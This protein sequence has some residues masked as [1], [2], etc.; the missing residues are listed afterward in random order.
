MSKNLLYEVSDVNTMMSADY[1]NT[2]GKF[3][4]LLYHKV[5]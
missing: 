2:D 5:E 4:I 3:V 1:I